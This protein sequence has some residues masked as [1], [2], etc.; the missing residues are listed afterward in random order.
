MYIIILVHFLGTKQA[1]FLQALSTAALVF[2]VT[3]GCATDNTCKCGKIP[4]PH[5]LRHEQKRRGKKN[6]YGGCHDN[7]AF[8]V[9]FSKRF[10]DKRE[11]KLSTA[12]DRKIVNLHNNDLGRKV[13]IT[14]CSFI[15]YTLM[16]AAEWLLA[17]FWYIH[18]YVWWILE[19][20]AR[21]S[22][23][24]STILD[25]FV[26]NL[27]LVYF[28]F[29][30]LWDQWVR[31]AAIFPLYF[32]TWRN[33][34]V[35]ISAYGTDFFLSQ[36]KCSAF[37]CSKLLYTSFSQTRI[38]QRVAPRESWFKHNPTLGCNRTIIIKQNL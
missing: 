10:L 34:P 18:I 8:G 9:R 30:L 38:Y 14:F 24:Y 3:R 19:T 32:Q 15:I 1:A 13:R 28:P 17:R 36:H 4:S 23:D 25:L 12:A 16:S 6:K 7:I 2:E 37:S 21:F 29:G 11:M 26:T 35:V 27:L 33:Y 22:D 20:I 5:L 31:P